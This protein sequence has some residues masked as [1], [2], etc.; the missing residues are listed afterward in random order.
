MR[1]FL[2][3]FFFIIILDFN[4]FACICSF[5][6]FAVYFIS[7]ESHASCADSSQKPSNKST[8]QITS[9]KAN[10]TSCSFVNDNFFFF[11]YSFFWL[12]ASN[13]IVRTASEHTFFWKK[14]PSKSLHEKDTSILINPHY[15]QFSTFLRNWNHSPGNLNFFHF[16]MYK[17]MTFQFDIL[18]IWRLFNKCHAQAKSPWRFWEATHILYILLKHFYWMKHFS[19][20][21]K[22]FSRD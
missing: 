22:Y 10:C 11:L 14:L 9:Q 3:L 18:T 8:T 20:L 5:I 6:A 17:E 7:K 19:F 1:L 4:Y 21:L 16:S 15:L 13:G 2:V 12:I